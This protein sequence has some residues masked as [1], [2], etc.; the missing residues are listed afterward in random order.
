MSPTIIV[1]RC[2]PVRL[3]FLDL[4]YNTRECLMMPQTLANMPMLSKHLPNLFH[5]HGEHLLEY[6]MWFDALV[7]EAFF[8]LFKR[9]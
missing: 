5:S 3:R 4:C 7:Q 2:T 6:F 8:D 1:M 9:S